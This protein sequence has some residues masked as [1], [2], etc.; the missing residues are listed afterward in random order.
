MAYR[1]VAFV[2]GGSTGDADTVAFPI[3]L[4]GDVIIGF[5]C[6]FTASARPISNSGASAFAGASSP[7]ATSAGNAAWFRAPSDA[8][9]V[10]C[11][12]NTASR[13]QIFGYRGASKLYGHAIQVDTGTVFTIPAVKSL[14]HGGRFFVSTITE[15]AARTVSSDDLGLGTVQSTNTS[16]GSRHRWIGPPSLASYPGGS[17][18]LNSSAECWTIYGWAI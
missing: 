10:T 14:R 12:V 8:I 1:S 7:S 4:T 13:F 11:S 3:S 5:T 6:N 16:G 9:D 15:T 18:T 2:N 17:F